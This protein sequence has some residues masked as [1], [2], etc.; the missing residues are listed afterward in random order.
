[1]GRG[2]TGEEPLKGGETKYKGEV[3][4]GEMEKECDDVEEETEHER[5]GKGGDT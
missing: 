3:R 4:G 2:G 5:E 1:M